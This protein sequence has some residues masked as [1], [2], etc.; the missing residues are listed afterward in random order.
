MSLTDTGSYIAAA[1]T[2]LVR[3][4][5][6]Y[7]NCRERSPILAGV[8]AVLFPTA[9]QIYNKQY[10]KAGAIWGVAFVTTIGTFGSWSNH[11]FHSNGT[12]SIFLTLLVLDG[13][14]A[15][16][17]A[18]LSSIYLNEKYHLGHKKRSFSSLHISP[19]LINAGTS[20][21]FDAGLSLILR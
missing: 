7:Q 16:V 10:A 21:K 6:R 15:L 20:N 17:D 19:D 13:T 4:P 5:L 12:T 11:N 2:A 1:D 8:L 18:P 9:G 14:F 3:V